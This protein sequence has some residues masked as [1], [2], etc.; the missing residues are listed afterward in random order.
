MKFDSDNMNKKKTVLIISLLVIFILGVSIASATNTTKDTTKKVNTPKKITNKE[1]IKKITKKINNKNVKAANNSKNKIYISTTGDDKKGTGLKDNPYKSLDKALNSSNNG[2]T[3]LFKKGIYKIEN[4]NATEINKNIT[5]TSLNKNKVILTSNKS[6]K[7]L[8]QIN[9]KNTVIIKNIEFKSINRAS[10]LINKG[11]LSINNVNFTSNKINVSPNK[12]LI[13]NYGIMKITSSRFNNNKAT[14]TPVFNKKT[15][16]ITNTIFNKNSA[17][18]SGAIINYKGKSTI[19]NSKFTNNHAD[20]QTQYAGT[21]IKIIK[22]LSIQSGG[23]ILNNANMNVEKCTFNKNDA[24][25]GGAIYNRGK[26]SIKN[27]KLSSNNASSQ[28][29]SIFSEKTLNIQKSTFTENN[30]P[31][32][33]A[34]YSF[35]GKIITKYANFS[36]NFAENSGG[37][38]LIRDTDTTIEKTNFTSNYAISV[39]YVAPDDESQDWYNYYGGAIMAYNSKLDIIKSIMTDNSALCGGAIAHANSTI[40]INNSKMIKNNAGYYGGVLSLYPNSEGTSKLTITDSIMKNNDA[41]FNGKAIF[42]GNSI[43]ALEDTPSSK[44]ILKN[45][46][47]NSNGKTNT[48]SKEAYSG[49][50][51]IISVMTPKITITNTTINKNKGQI[52]FTVAGGK[53]SISKCTIKENTY[54]KGSLIDLCAE[55][56]IINTKITDNNAKIIVKQEYG[57]NEN[58]ILIKKCVLNNSKAK[59]EVYNKNNSTES[60]NS[61]KIVDTKVAKS[62]LYNCLA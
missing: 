52:L 37:A 24:V 11:K 1:I 62:K 3:I 43:E 61:V 38:I 55:T 44:I 56:K 19:K 54:T 28:A 18:Y 31:E 8:M 7:G 20:S 57:L 5:L 46:Q 14:C 27:S 47:I 15:L 4:K 60:V 23:A 29:G 22:G 41:L 25:I 48:A 42:D 10:I 59:Y 40:N 36:K 9:S 50:D 13:N 33:G 39:G 2:D 49:V 35:K 21:G 51:S 53:A 45:C 26:I 58:N 12:S 32:G 34:I 30:A 17:D 16:T 6:N